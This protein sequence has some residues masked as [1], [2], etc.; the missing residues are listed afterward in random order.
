MCIDEIYVV[1]GLNKPSRFKVSRNA[2]LEGRPT[3]YGRRRSF[4]GIASRY[5]ALDDGFTIARLA[6]APGSNLPIV[7]SRRRSAFVSGAAGDGDRASGPLG[8][9]NALKANLG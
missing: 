5:G 8:S 7:P 1:W 4:A 3:T 2:C 9:S 6:F